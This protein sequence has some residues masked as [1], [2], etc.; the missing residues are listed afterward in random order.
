MSEVLRRYL[1]RCWPLLRLKGPADLSA[2]ARGHRRPPFCG[3]RLEQLAAFGKVR[4]VN[5][6]FAGCVRGGACY[7]LISEY[8]CMFLAFSVDLEEGR[9]KGT[10]ILK[11]MPELHINL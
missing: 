8:L 9:L 1:A 6:R 4:F 7:L 11:P 2:L 3:R 5:R 10:S